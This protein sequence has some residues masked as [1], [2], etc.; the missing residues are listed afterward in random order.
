MATPKSRTLM[1]TGNDF[2][3][4]MGERHPDGFFDGNYFQHNFGLLG[5]L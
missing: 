2:G 1:A 4:V 3:N 5:T